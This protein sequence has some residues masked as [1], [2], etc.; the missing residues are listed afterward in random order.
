MQ[1]GE[2]QEYYG[3]FQHAGVQVYAVSVDSPEDNAR[4]KARLEAG[5]EFLSDP[6]AE[7]LAALDITQA[8]RSPSLKVCAIP[9]QY[10]LDQNGIVR[11][12]HR[13]ETWRVRPHPKEALQAIEQLASPEKLQPAAT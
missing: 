1:L 4:L 10:L 9:T 3:E 12:F 8:N 7:L 5:Y 11:W 13:A 6:K 2:L